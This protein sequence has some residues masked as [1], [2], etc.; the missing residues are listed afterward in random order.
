MSRAEVHAS[1][2]RQ[3]AINGKSPRRVHDTGA[4]AFSEGLDVAHTRR[5]S[6]DHRLVSPPGRACG[7]ISQM[8]ITRWEGEPP[9]LLGPKAV[10]R[11]R[12]A[13]RSNP[14]RPKVRDPTRFPSAA[15][16]RAAGGKAPNTGFHI[17]LRARRRRA[18]S[19]HRTMD[20]PCPIPRIFRWTPMP[21]TW[22][23]GTVLNRLPPGL[24]G[25]A[26]GIRRRSLR[27]RCGR[28]NRRI[29][30]RGRCGRGAAR[31]LAPRVSRARRERLRGRVP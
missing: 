2:P 21:R 3:M 6:L 4:A 31:S 14:P 27:C 5:S 29:R 12:A 17:E 25:G 1:P 18:C 9:R 15:P 19:C 10:L 22:L 30:R 16:P 26:V 23:R 11:L 28:R 20:S 13:T 7:R 24:L 8:P